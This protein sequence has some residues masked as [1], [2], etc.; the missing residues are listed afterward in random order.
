[1][2]DTGFYIK[3]K[4]SSVAVQGGQLWR[5]KK[6]EGKAMEFD[7]QRQEIR[8][9]LTPQLEMTDMRD[10]L[11]QQIRALHPWRYFFFAL[12][13]RLPSLL[14]LIPI[15]LTVSFIGFITIY[16]D[17]I[18]NW[19]LMFD[20][21]QTI[22]G[23]TQHQS[24][25]IYTLLAILI[26][27]FFPVFLTGEQ[28]GFV[29]AI[30]ERFS[31]RQLMRKRFA[32]A[33][34]F[35]AQK[36]HLV[37]VV[38]W[39]PN[40]VKDEKDWVQKS[41]I[42]ALLDAKLATALQVKTD[43]RSSVEQYIARISD[44][45]HSSWTEV[46]QETVEASQP[47]PYDYLK[48][49]EIKLLSVYVFCS[50]AN[51]PTDWNPKE[52]PAKNFDTALSLSLVK[53]VIERFADRLFS[54]E[55]RK[56]LISLD[57]FASR[58][59]NDFGILKPC[60]TY[61]NDVWALHP[62]VV[63]QQLKTV[64]EEMHFIWAFWQNEVLSLRTRLN[65]PVAALLLN[66]VQYNQA[67]YD[68]GRLAALRFFVEVSHETEQY[69]ILKQYWPIVA[70]TASTSDLYRILGVELLDNLATLFERAAM[71]AQATEALTYLENVFPYRGQ[72]GK[73]RVLER[74][75][76]FER[77]VQAMLSIKTAWEKETISL[78]T[79]ALVD[80][81]LNLAWAIVSGR[82]ETQKALG[83]SA[84]EV[85]YQHLYARF[86]EVRNSE[87]IIRLY[88]IRAN[89]EEWDN[90]LDKALENY[91]QALQIPG[92]PQAAL[93]NLLVN[94]GIVLRKTG[95]LSDAVLFGKQ[96]VDIKSAIGDADQLP[97]ALHNLAQTTLMLGVKNLQKTTFKQ[98]LQAAQQGLTIQAQTG[99][100]KKRGQLL[101]EQFIACFFLKNGQAEAQWHAL[102]EWLK[103]QQGQT[104][105]YDCWVVLNELLSL[106]PNPPQSTIEAVLNWTLTS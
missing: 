11:Y 2:Q 76:N 1:M 79:D 20:N 66:A 101:A 103:M 3:N 18:K 10:L 64:Q 58:C 78:H 80:L 35:L 71:Y 74:Q 63:E 50:M 70:K 48:S 21:G 54:E 30:N 33:F 72:M 31:N 26:L 98:A 27:Y 88:N 82:L 14:L 90:A 65:D 81:H 17:L 7:A 4:A 9:Y 23:L 19:V 57:A 91:N 32:K 51:T 47:I 85:A 49:W 12:S 60:L 67:I 52:T 106:L 62:Q 105:S 89:Y 25:P 8:V 104:Q 61:T 41:L 46:S 83:R 53:I 59:L 6:L 45:K 40:L 84:L 77:A 69:Q 96:G 38:L 87:Q 39:N 36:G 94:K 24:I 34:K 43:E 15:T 56:Y 92:V 44:Q 5:A 86:D 37:R 55:D 99:S 97:I 13:K 93:S 28:D 16:G 42:P 22:F 68:Q 95:Q 29:Q 100:T 75:G 73:A 102:K